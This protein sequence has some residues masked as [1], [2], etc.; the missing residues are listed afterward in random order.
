MWLSEIDG[1]NKN[2]MYSNEQASNIQPLEQFC[3]G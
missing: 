2:I 1:G 3:H